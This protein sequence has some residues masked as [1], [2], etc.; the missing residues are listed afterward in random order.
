[1]IEI[2]WDILI[3]TIYV[4]VF[5]NYY[6]AQNV[7]NSCYCVVKIGNDN[8]YFSRQQWI[9]ANYVCL[10]HINIDVVSLCEHP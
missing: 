1:M 6:D 2:T 8:A 4:S 7:E 5:S 9:L 3:A 10:K